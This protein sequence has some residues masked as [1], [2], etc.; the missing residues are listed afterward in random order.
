M[1]DLAASSCGLRGSRWGAGDHG[2][3]AAVRSL[4]VFRVLTAK[5]DR[6]AAIFRGSEDL[7]VGVAQTSRFREAVRH[8]LWLVTRHQRLDVDTAIPLVRRVGRGRCVLGG[9]QCWGVRSCQ[10]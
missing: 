3:L 7:G 6:L 10:I 8:F 5:L 9:V 4:G 1:R 2:P